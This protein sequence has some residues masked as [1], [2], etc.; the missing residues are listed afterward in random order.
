MD[1]RNEVGSTWREVGRHKKKTSLKR[2]W[3]YTNRKDN[4]D[5]LISIICRV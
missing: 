2:D 3:F 1:V 5:Y 4:N